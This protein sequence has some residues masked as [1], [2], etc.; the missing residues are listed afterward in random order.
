[1]CTWKFNTIERIRVIAKEISS[2]AAKN[3]LAIYQILNPKL[4][5]NARWQSK[6]YKGDYIDYMEQAIHRFLSSCE[7][8]V[9][10][11]TQI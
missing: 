5:H 2:P 3:S 10:M 11:Y 9:S 8:Q 7:V 6:G 4:Y 1:M